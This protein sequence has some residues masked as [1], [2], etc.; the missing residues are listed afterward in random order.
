MKRKLDLKFEEIANLVSFP[1]TEKGYLENDLDKKIE[2]NPSSKSIIFAIGDEIN[3]AT[4]DIHEELFVGNIFL[5]VENRFVEYKPLDPVTS[6]INYVKRP[7]RSDHRKYKSFNFQNFMKNIKEKK[8]LQI[9]KKE[10]REKIE[11]EKRLEEE[12]LAQEKAKKE[13]ERVIQ[14]RIKMLRES[15]LKK[16]FKFFKKG[17]ISKPEKK[18]NM[19]FRKKEKKE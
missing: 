15:K 3:Q 18:R 17:K 13:K 16:K 4:N 14:E 19:K 1:N 5:E 12:K 7:W 8:E 10:E 9:R 2:K 11:K 6:S